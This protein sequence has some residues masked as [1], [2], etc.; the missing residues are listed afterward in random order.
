MNDF[1][2]MKK[3]RFILMQLK[4]DE[5]LNM[6]H[7]LRLNV[8]NTKIDMFNKLYHYIRSNNFQLLEEI[9]N[10]RVQ[11]AI[12]N[13]QQTAGVSTSASTDAEASK[14][15]KMNYYE[16]LHKDIDILE[17]F[18]NISKYTK[19]FDGSINHGLR[20]DRLSMKSYEIVKD[21]L[22]ALAETKPIEYELILYR[23]ISPDEKYNIVDHKPGDVLSD[24]GF[25]SK[26]N[27]MSEARRFTNDK[28]DVA[29]SLYI[30]Q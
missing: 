9:V 17:K 12:E 6:C 2:D 13:I 23:G 1:S 8:K 26:T 25:M 5:L 7:Q 3:L 16:F 15:N 28:S 18:P 19:W 24:P 10:S 4:K 27:T 22:A 21:I 29:C 20:K 11:K 30:I 14:K